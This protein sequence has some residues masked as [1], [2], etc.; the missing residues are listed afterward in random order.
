[1]ANPAVF[2]NAIDAITVMN[3]AV[4]NIR[5]YPPSSA[6]IRNTV[7]RVHQLLSQ[8]LAQEKSV[9]L[10]ESGQNFVVCGHVFD[11]ADQK[12]HPQANSLL[13]LFSRFGLKSVSFEQRLA[14]SELKTFLQIISR[15]PSDVEAEGGLQEVV[16]RQKLPNIL[17]DH[18]VYVVVDKDQQIVA[19]VD[20]RDEDIVKYLTGFGELSEA[21][22]RKIREMARDPQWVAKV[23]QA[24]MAF[25]V[26]QKGESSY[27]KISEVVGH[28]I[29]TLD[30]IS[31]EV[32]RDKITRELAAAIVDMDE[33]M[34]APILTQEAEGRFSE[35]LFDQVIEALDDE[36]FER[37]TARIQQ[38]GND[39]N[40]ESD[41]AAQAYRYLMSSGK[42]QR[43]RDRIRRRQIQERKKRERRM[44]LLK[45]GLTRIVRGEM[46]PFLET[47][48]TE[49]LP[50]YARQLIS[51][52]RSRTIRTLLEKLSTG[53]SDERPEVR[54]KAA[55]ALVDVGRPILADGRIAPMAES[56]PAWIHWIQSET[57]LSEA[58]PHLVR[59]LQDLAREMIRA[60]VFA[61]TEPI[62]ETFHQIRYREGHPDPVVRDLA[63]EALREI[64]TTDVLDL[65]LEEFQT[66]AEEHRRQA[67]HL[68][69]LFGEASMDRLLDLLAESR[70]MSIRVRILQMLSEIGA[71][72]PGALIR[73]I[74][75]GGA[76]YYLRNLILMLGKVGR[77]EHL[78]VLVP[79]LKHEDFRVRRETLNSIYNIGG[80]RRGEVLVNALPEA[81]DRLRLNIVDMLGAL[82]HKP[83]ARPLMDLI[84]G[85]KSFFS[86]KVSDRLQEKICAALGRIGAEEAV[87]M[88]SNI[89]GQKGLL[90]LRSFP[91]NV[92]EAAAHALANIGRADAGASEAGAK[93]TLPGRK[94][95]LPGAGAPKPKTPKVVSTD[96]TLPAAPGERVVKRNDDTVEENVVEMLM[97]AIQEAARAGDFDRAEALRQQLVELDG[98]ALTEIIQAGEIIERERADPSTEVEVDADHLGIW[99]ELYDSLTREE[100]EALYEALAETEL[101]AD[102]AVFEQGKPGRRLY[103]VHGGQLKQVFM[104][105]ERENLL[106]TV[107]KGDIAGE[108]TF[109][110]ISVC[111]TSLVTLNRCRV[112]YLDRK[113]LETWREHFPAL[114]SKLHD[115]C[116]RLDRIQDILRNKGIE[117]RRQERFII[118]GVVDVQLLNS[119][120]APTGK[121]FKGN[122]RDISVGGIS[123]GIRSP[124]RKNIS[125]LL[126]RNLEMLLDFPAAL[127]PALGV[128]MMVSQGSPKIRI[129]HVG[130]VI[131][132]SHMSGE[133]YAVHIK[134][135][136]LLSGE[137]PD[138]DEAAAAE[139]P[140]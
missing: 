8:I 80:D 87:P 10:A 134:F 65:L 30:D 39:D 51:A 42:G 96:L 124:S 44:A 102:E 58:Y 60:E 33:E 106:K 71:P 139:S 54:E 138:A 126:G 100:S 1:M 43:L 41:P 132:V 94:L 127:G 68:L 108:E 47:E 67:I 109:F 78:R 35:A 36:K 125:L 69:A 25:I 55:A 40:G 37:I 116:L 86:T 75:R 56:A 85:G 57:H 92:R 137:D 15:N 121:T 63:G 23:F 123:F 26:R 98:L 77:E 95:T 12:R 49:A 112:S 72:A 107:G 70:D 130:T 27:H 62:L 18:K 32:N 115:Y 79:L 129:K 14:K 22:I 90:G 52:G 4:T 140:G 64:A 82:G 11:E 2:K 114:E 24:G 16:R 81:D 84:E 21:D 97:G 9:I 59:L 31:D 133:D 119:S 118:A 131:G 113:I 104:S 66:G 48:F 3:V 93:L 128:E 34:M 13:E 29:R 111:T 7:D 73:R 99:P 105:G 120:G 5:L 28:M 135:E 61:E 17:M 46:A 50:E 19:G 38:M 45:D 6:I 122:L 110:G 76:W 117:R 103:F 53:L 74:E 20:V 83:A 88:L 136:S 101:P 89:A 91:D